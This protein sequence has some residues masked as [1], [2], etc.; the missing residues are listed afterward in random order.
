LKL[1]ALLAPPLVVTLTFSQPNPAL[2]G[3][4]HLM[5]VAFQRH[6]CSTSWRRT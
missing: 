1:L 4:R 2:A 6:T 3:T 5:R